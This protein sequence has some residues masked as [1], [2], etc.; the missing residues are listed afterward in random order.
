[1]SWLDDLSD[2]FGSG[3]DSDLSSALSSAADSS[4]N[5]GDYLPSVSMSDFQM[6]PYL[7]NISPDMSFLDFQM[8]PY[9]SD[10]VS[11]IRDVLY[12]AVSGGSLGLSPTDSY[13]NFGDSAY[14]GYATG[15]VG[16]AYT[17]GGTT[18]SWFDKLN[19]YGKLLET[20]GG[21][22]L[23]GLGGAGIGAIGAFKQNALLK[24]AAKK[25]AEMLAARQAKA[26]LYDSPL[27]LTLARQAVA[28]PT[29]R[30]GASV[31]FTNNKLPSAYAAGGSTNYVQGGT[32]GQDDKIPAQLSDGEYVIDADVVSALGDGNNEAGAKKLDGMR[33]AVRSHKRSAPASKIPPKAKSPLEYMKKGAK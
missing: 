16:G 19:E 18:P 23:T 22:L 2:L 28:A 3:S 26:E 33:E 21:K 5:F 11:S 24:A 30:N 20:P 31:F 14:G 17:T 1:M 29:P 32:A 7:A 6:D 4:G 25:Q 12:P 15:P 27:R 8:D 13:G 10:S 9:Q